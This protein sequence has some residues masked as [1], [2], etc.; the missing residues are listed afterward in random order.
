[1]RH[2]VRER[3]C[4]AVTPRL[5]IEVTPGIRQALELLAQASIDLLDE[6]DAPADGLEADPDFEVTFDDDEDTHD[7]EEDEDENDLGWSE[8]PGGTTFGHGEAKDEDFVAPETSG[9]LIPPPEPGAVVWPSF[10]RAAQRALFDPRIARRPEV[11]RCGG[12]HPIP[13][14]PHGAPDRPALRI[15]DEMQRLTLALAALDARRRRAAR[16]K[17]SSRSNRAR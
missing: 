7:A 16:P 8:F 3:E 6:I 13:P 10:D 4:H 2:M 15:G 14:F 9:G 1:M 5:F 17:H 12:G 11:S